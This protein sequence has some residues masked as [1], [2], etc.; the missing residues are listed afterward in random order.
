MFRATFYLLLAGSIWF[1]EGFLFSKFL[2]FTLL[3]T[4][5]AAIFYVL[6]Y[7]AVVRQLT[8]AFRRDDAR[9]DAARWRYL[10]LAPM[11]TVV[12][13]SFASLGVMLLIVMA[14]QFL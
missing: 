8:L 4:T 2:G 13:G 10:S 6:V 7:V 1:V 11:L 5:G 9:G 14:G 3:Q 12:V